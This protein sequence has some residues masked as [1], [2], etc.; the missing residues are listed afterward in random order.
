MAF[1]GCSGLTSITIPD[2]V[3][4][5]GDEA[6][7]YCGSLEGVYITDLEAWCAM[8]FSGSYSNPLYYAGNLYLNGRLVTELVIPDDITSIGN[9]AFEYCSSLISITIPDGV[10]SIGAGAF[11]YCSSLESITIPD[12]V[13]SIGDSAFAYCGRLTSITIP[14]SVTSIGGYAFRYCDSL[15]S[16]VIGNGVTSIG[17]SAF[18]DCDSLTSIT[19]ASGNPVYHSAGNCLIETDSKTLIAGCKNSIIPTDGS[20]T[21]IGDWAFYNCDS[22]TSITIPDSVTSI[23]DEAFRS[24]SSLTSITIPDSVTSIG[25]WAFR[26]CDSLETV[27]YAGSGEDWEKIDIGAYNSDLTTAEIIFNYGN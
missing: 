25:D 2:S 6:F 8:N 1:Y 20:V 12:S 27:Y 17:G 10:T 23:G 4:S 24:C 16:V 26:F 11:W 15:T 7:W 3:T 22:L 18:E 19:V 21:S 5:I 14:D 13:T 9:S